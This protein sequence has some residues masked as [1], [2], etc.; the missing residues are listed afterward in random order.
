[1]RERRDSYRKKAH[2]RGIRGVFR[3]SER[4]IAERSGVSVSRWHSD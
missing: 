1:M 2:G 3:V 4:E